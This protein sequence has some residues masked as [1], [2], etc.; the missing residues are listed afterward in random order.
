MELD[1]LG[2]VRVARS[3]N[4]IGDGCPKPQ[5][6]TLKALNQL[7]EGSVVELISDNPSAVETI[8]SMM[9][10]AYGVHIATVR[11]HSC[12]KVYVRKGY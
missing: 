10:A 2:R 6:L 5:L 4:C 1:G 7:P 3:V 11:D 12:W 8:P 9:M